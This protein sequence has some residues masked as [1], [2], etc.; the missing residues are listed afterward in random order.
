MKRLLPSCLLVAL[1]LVPRTGQGDEDLDR[2]W[3]ARSAPGGLQRALA[4]LEGAVRSGTA[5]RL[6]FERLVRLRFFQGDR[7]L[8]DG[9]PVRMTAW[10]QCVAD[11]LQGL[12]RHGA[13][14]G[15]PIRDMEDVDHLRDR[16]ERPAVGILFW[17]TLCYGN[18]IPGFS[19]FRQ[20]SGA[21]RFHRLLRRCL[22]LDE[23]YFQAGPHRTLA[24][25]LHQAP[26]IMGGNDD[27]AVIHAE[28]AVRLFP[29]WAE[30]RLC[31]ARN[32]WLP[33]KDRDRFRQD[34][35]AALEA[36]DDAFP[37]AVPEQRAAREEA[38]R[39]LASPDGMPR[40]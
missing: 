1:A 3:T 31:R 10:K 37:D 36:P 28:A 20:A 16:I 30:N 4:A 11:G 24:D 40:P 35:E 14:G 32:V 22:A 7:V 33:R 2:T 26:G 8:P 27:L 34:L 39:I 19:L 21:R 13:D 38:R 12:A 5:D 9:S 29:R 25:F 23:T 6:S 15:L 18:T 17:T